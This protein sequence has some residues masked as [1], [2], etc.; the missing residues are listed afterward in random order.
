VKVTI[1]ENEE[2]SS[3]EV[4]IHCYNEDLRI[5]KIRNFIE[6]FDSKISAKEE[7]EIFMVHPEEVYYIESIDKRTYIYLKGKVLECSLKLYELE[8]KYKAFSFFRA[9][10]SS[11]I[12]TMFIRKVVPM[13]NRNL[14]VTLENDEK[15]IISRR[16]VKEFNKLIGL[17]REGEKYGNDYE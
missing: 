7:N 14:M 3:D 9:T 2:L 17:E 6:S 11:I 4:V 5:K 10:K 15:V 12:N 1:K 8:E 13:L 16:N